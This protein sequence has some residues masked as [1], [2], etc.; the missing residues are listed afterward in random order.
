MFSG[1]YMAVMTHYRVAMVH[2]QVVMEHYMVVMGA[3]QRVIQLIAGWYCRI[4]GCN[5]F[6]ATCYKVLNKLFCHQ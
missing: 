4:T 1:H 2:Y 6:I 5:E 3:L